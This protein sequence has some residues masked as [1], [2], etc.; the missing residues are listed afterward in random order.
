MALAIGNGRHGYRMRNSV[1]IKLYENVAVANRLAGIY[2][3]IKD[4][5]GTDRDLKLDPFEQT[6]SMVVVGGRLIFNGSG[7]V[8]IDRPLS[9][10]LYNV[11]LLAPSKQAGIQMTGVLGRHQAEILDILVRQRLAAVIQPAD[12]QTAVAD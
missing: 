7:P 11:E 10:E 5:T 2:G 4:L 12:Q 9:A 3:H 8:T 6:V 1:D